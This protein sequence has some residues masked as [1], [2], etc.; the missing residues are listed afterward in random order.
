MF[1]LI[2]Q[3]YV[4]IRCYI[5]FNFLDFALMLLF[6]Y[7]LLCS[8]FFVAL[9]AAAVVA[10]NLRSPFA[11]LFLFAA[12]PSFLPYFYRLSAFICL[13]S[14]IPIYDIYWT[15]PSPCSIE[16]LDADNPVQDLSFAYLNLIP[17]FSAFKS[18]FQAL[19]A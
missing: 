10:L 15:P 8:T 19:K 17:W 7:F 18:A 11:F 5:K 13:N 14:P 3:V 2:L 16:W 1:Y 4:S 6:N 9:L 12:S